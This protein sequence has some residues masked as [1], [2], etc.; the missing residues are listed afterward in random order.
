MTLIVASLLWAGSCSFL[1]L[2]VAHTVKA[3][4]IAP[5]L[6]ERSSKGKSLASFLAGSLREVTRKGSASAW[7]DISYALASHI[8]AGEPVVQAFRSVS[9]EGVDPAYSTVAR[10]VQLYD[11]GSTFTDALEAESKGCRELA[12]L[13][14]ILEMGN[15]AGGDLPT[16]LCHAAESM[17]RSRSLRNEARSRLA[18]ARGTAALLSLLPWLIG[19]LTVFRDQR[20]RRAAFSDPRGKGLFVLAAVLWVIGTVAIVLLLKS[21]GTKPFRLPSRE[22]GTKR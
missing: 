11:A 12:Y 16:L 10:V 13:T 14:G 20:L 7:E 3:W 15:A 19:W 5:A 17:R 2:D 8:R 22:R 4:N 18:E 9:S 6:L 21:L 1:C